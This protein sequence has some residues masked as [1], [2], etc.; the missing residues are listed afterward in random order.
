MFGSKK[1]CVARPQ[2]RVQPVREHGDRSGMASRASGYDDAH[3][4]PLRLPNGRGTLTSQDRNDIWQ[5]YKVS[6]SVRFRQQWGERCL[7]LTGPASALTDAKAMAEQRIQDNGDEHGRAEDPTVNNLRVQQ[8]I[9]DQELRKQSGIIQYMQNQVV[10]A[11]A[12]AQHAINVATQASVAAAEA[13][14]LAKA[15][16]KEN[17]AN[18]QQYMDE[19][20]QERAKRSAK[21]ALRE[22]E[23]KKGEADPKSSRSS[24]TTPRSQASDGEKKNAYPHPAAGVKQEMPSPTSPAEEEAP[25]TEKREAKGEA[26][27][28]METVD[29]TETELKKETLEES[30]ECPTVTP[31][32]IQVDYSPAPTNVTDLG[33][34]LPIPAAELPGAEDPPMEEQPGQ[35]DPPMTQAGQEEPRMTETLAEEQAATPVPAESS[36]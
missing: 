25:K 17:A 2:A 32:E 22:E 11:D 1:T 20:A 26:K 12:R 18:L 27:D 36:G 7:T 4:G 8:G 24:L 15:L 23:R 19:R 16:A 10:T 29:K 9:L 34:D 13:M 5:R 30:R 3:M 31:S 6:A 28:N 33:T 14:S 35:E 21:R